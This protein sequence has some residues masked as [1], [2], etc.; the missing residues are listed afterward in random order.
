MSKKAASKFPPAIVRAHKNYVNAI[1][2]NDIDRVMANYDKD[3]VVMQPDGPL[4]KGHGPLRKWVA[5]YFYGYK[6]HWVKISK[7]MW[8]AGDYG[9]DQ[10][11]DTAA[12]SYTH[13][14]LPTSDLV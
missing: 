3:A 13:L 8:M 2:S 5:D 11:H 7:V 10:G 9:F 1:N 12:V 6:T 4:V 14:T